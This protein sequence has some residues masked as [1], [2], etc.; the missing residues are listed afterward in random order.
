MPLDKDQIKATE[1]LSPLAS[2]DAADS[3]S[4]SPSDSSE[5][6]SESESESESESS[7][8]SSDESSE[9]PSDDDD[10]GSSDDDV[11]AAAD[12]DSGSSKIPM[13]IGIV[14]GVLVLI[15]LISWGA[16]YYFRKKKKNQQNAAYPDD[17]SHLPTYNSD[18]YSDY[19]GND[20]YGNRGDYY[21][22]SYSDYPNKTSG[23]DYKY[24]KH[25]SSAYDP[26]H[27]SNVGGWGR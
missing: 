14:A 18:D 10:E 13:Y 7:D 15:G 2:S 6:P 17:S 19:G 8:D 23:D 1:D 9:D 26:Q 4:E 11:A 24:A 16:L 25:Y 5:D 27:Q 22:T 21:A 3:D 12:K 20:D